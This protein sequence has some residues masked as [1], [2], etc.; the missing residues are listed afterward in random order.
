MRR[1]GEDMHPPDGFEAGTACLF[2]SILFAI[3]VVITAVILTL[4]LLIAWK[5]FTKAGYSGAMSLLLLVPVVG[6]GVMLWFAFTNW[7]VE[8]EVKIL[9]MRIKSLER[10]RDQP[11]Q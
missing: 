9:R 2:T 7:P 5:V 10:E 6:I 11:P 3:M 8:N 1:G 4:A